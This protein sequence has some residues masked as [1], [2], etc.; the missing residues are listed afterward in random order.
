MA[1]VRI[2]SIPGLQSL[3]RKRGLSV[4]RGLFVAAVLVQAA[5]AS[6][7]EAQAGAETRGPAASSPVVTEAKPALS[8]ALEVAL[9]RVQGLLVDPSDAAIRAAFAPS[10]LEHIPVERSREVFQRVNTRA[11]SCR[12]Y[13]ITSIESETRAVVRLPCARGAVRVELT[14]EPAAPHLMTRLLL[15]PAS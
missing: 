11:G 4:A 5:C 1:C 10:F 15:K 2:P 9:Q 12:A 3:S 14:I 7:P 6:A 13:E 8:P